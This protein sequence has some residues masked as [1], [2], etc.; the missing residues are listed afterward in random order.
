MSESRYS[1][2]IIDAIL[3]GSLIKRVGNYSKYSQPIKV[4]CLACNNNWEIKIKNLN[5]GT[6]CPN[7]F[8][9]RRGDSRRLSKEEIIKRAICAHGDKYDYSKIEY[10]N[11]HKK[12]IIICKV[13]G[14][15]FQ[16]LSNHINKKQNCPD[17]AGIIR[18]DD[19]KI[20][21]YLINNNR[22]IKRLSSFEASNKKM[23]WQCLACQY[24]W[25]TSFQAIHIAETGCPKCNDTSFS[26]EIIDKFLQDNKP[27]IIRLDEYINTTTKIKWKCLDC[28]NIWYAK[29]QELLRKNPNRIV[30]CPFKCAR[31][32]N[33]R[34][35]CDTLRQLNIEFIPQFNIKLPINKYNSRVDVFIPSISMIIEYNGIQHYHPTQFGN[36][37]LDD[38]CKSFKKTQ[39]RDKELEVY[40]L[41]NNLKL[42]FI[43]G[44]KYK[45]NN[46]KNFI[47][48][49]FNNVTE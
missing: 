15:F 2:E 11:L 39:L 34:I 41:I 43:D 6:G 44:R 12:V 47:I 20:D 35:L 45:G 38:A 26:N 31:G 19:D 30:G 27:S 3:N 4:E 10:N 14:E 18:Y 28:E 17:C 36:M 37:S 40:C 16:T 49:I 33:E 7:C 1:N 25:I 22:N 46:L 21:E 23:H 5:K 24:Q 9:S 29:P 42:L 48:E 8:N 13:H 32:K